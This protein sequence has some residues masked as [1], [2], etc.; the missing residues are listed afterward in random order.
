[1]SADQCRYMQAAYP[2]LDAEDTCSEHRHDEP[3]FALARAMAAAF[4]QPAPTDEQIGWCLDNAAAVVDDFNPPPWAWSVTAPELTDEPGLE[5]T[6]WINSHEYVLQP[7]EWGPSRP[8]SREQWREWQDED[9]DHDWTLRPESDTRV[10][11]M[12]GAER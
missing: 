1:M 5:F 3:T 11:E 2:T 7:S 4:Q 12:C 8:V 6:L 9:C 10:C